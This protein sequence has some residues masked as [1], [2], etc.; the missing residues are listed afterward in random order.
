MLYII[1][2]DDKEIFKRK[3]YYGYNASWNTDWATEDAPY[4]GDI[5]KDLKNTYKPN[6]IKVVQGWNVFSDKPVSMTDV[7]KF[8]KCY[9]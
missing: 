7:E 9:M 3:Y 8:E 1:N 2:E 6:V 5:I 4:T